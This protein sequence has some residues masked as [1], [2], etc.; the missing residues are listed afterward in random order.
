MNGTTE[1]ILWPFDQRSEPS[2]RCDIC[3][4]RLEW[5]EIEDNCN[6]NGM[7]LCDTCASELTMLE[8]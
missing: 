5:Y 4:C 6:I 3:N 8:E 1:H 2:D 7:T